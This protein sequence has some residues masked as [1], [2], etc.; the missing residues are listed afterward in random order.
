MKLVLLTYG[1]NVGFFHKGVRKSSGNEEKLWLSR[2]QL[3]FV[4]MLLAG[5]CHVKGQLWKLGLVDDLT[6]RMCQNRI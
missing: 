1:R 4:K 6:C 3:K 5:H 2:N